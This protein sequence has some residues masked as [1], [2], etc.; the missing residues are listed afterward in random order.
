VFTPAPTGACQ[1]VTEVLPHRDRAFRSN[2][3]LF[4]EQGRVKLGARGPCRTQGRQTVIP[5][6]NVVVDEA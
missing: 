4:V 5:T 1:D 6:A 2:D 3:A